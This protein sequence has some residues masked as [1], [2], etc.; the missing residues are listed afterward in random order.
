MYERIRNLREDKDLSQQAIANI[1]SISQTTY[2]RYETGVLDIPSISLIKLADFH[3]TSIDYI[4]GLTNE[5]K[6]Y[7]RKVKKPL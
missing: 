6:P 7:L 2:S 4:V 1:L 3:K 5:I